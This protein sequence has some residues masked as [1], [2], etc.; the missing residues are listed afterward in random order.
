[1]E[2]PIPIIK[3]KGN[4]FE[5][6]HIHGVS[7]K[8]KISRNVDYYLGWWSRNLDLD[9]N[10]VK[11]YGSKVLEILEK[12][13]KSIHKE[14][15][16]VS[17]GSEIEPEL[18]SAINGRY[19]LA[20]ASKDQL[21]GG[22][23]S[24]TSLPGSVKENN[25]LLAQNWDYRLSVRE[26]CIILEIEQDSGHSIVMHTEA[27]IIGQKGFNSEGLGLVINAMVSDRDKMGETVPFFAVCRA[28]LNESRFDKAVQVLLKAP[29]TVSYNVMMA[30]RG[31]VAVD[32][33]THPFETSVI[34]PENGSMVHTNHFVGERCFYLVDE[35]VK[36]EPSSIHRYHIAHDIL[37]AK[38]G[39]H[40]LETFKQILMNH[41][42]Y[43]ASICHHPDSEKLEDK[44][45]ETITS[46]IYELDGGKLFFTDGPPCENDYYLYIPDFIEK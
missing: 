43:P 3:T 12:F 28:M 11:N 10:Y 39:N 30:M 38:T 16:G 2:Y 35:F 34:L 4:P 23:T 20:W 7:A 13:D 27:G 32:L 9:I 18:I 24:I 45:E 15:L 21:M 36:D 37:K 29:R 6:G 22:C 5:C 46:V 19:E 25:T 8:D 41:F 17:E 31:G 40:S 26:N 44:Q 1:M 33:E 14:I 42:A